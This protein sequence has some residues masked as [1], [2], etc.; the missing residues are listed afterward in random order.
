ENDDFRFNG[1][2]FMED[3]GAV[4]AMLDEDEEQFKKDNLIAD[5][6][7]VNLTVA[8]VRAEDQSFMNM[9]IG[10]YMA[11]RSGEIGSLT[12][13]TKRPE[14]GMP[15]YSPPIA[16]TVLPMLL[17]SEIYTPINTKLT[18]AKPKDDFSYLKKPPKFMLD[19]SLPNSGDQSKMPL[20]ATKT[21][22]MDPRPSGQQDSN[23]LF[24]SE[25]NNS[26]KPAHK[27]SDDNPADTFVTRPSDGAP[28]TSAE[29]PL[30]TG[31]KNSNDNPAA[32]PHQQRASCE[33]ATHTP[34][35]TSKKM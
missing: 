24:D 22:N 25:C 21:P 16:R 31:H 6:H 19:E 2:D 27:L 20:P 7:L 35:R 12:S 30:V 29:S 26:G 23:G 32:D 17:P 8:S 13:P 10:T 11:A 18:R 34:P 3:S 1:E 9:T 28:K 4:A 33:S 5:E 14:F 15:V